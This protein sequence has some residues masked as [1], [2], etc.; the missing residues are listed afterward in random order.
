MDGRIKNAAPKTHGALLGIRDNRSMRRRCETQ[1]PANRFS[2]DYLYPFQE[3]MLVTC[4][5]DDAIEQ[6]DMGPAMIRSAAKNFR[7]VAVAVRH[8]VCR[9]SLRNLRT[10]E[11]R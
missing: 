10:M 3:T 1:H 4:D 8:L 2:G 7:D 9:K 11:G 5:L 6:I